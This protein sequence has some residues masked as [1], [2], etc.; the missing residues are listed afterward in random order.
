[1]APPRRI[2]IYSTVL[3][4]IKL[5]HIRECFD[6]QVVHVG[7][8]LSVM[9]NRVVIIIESSRSDGGDFEINQSVVI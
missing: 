4:L 5:F 1:M 9:L 3:L 2:S 6:Q 7:K 8:L